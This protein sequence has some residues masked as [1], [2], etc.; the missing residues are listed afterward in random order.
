M[1]EEQWKP[2][3][4]VAAIIERDKRFLIVEE[5]INGQLMLN[6]P[7]GHWEDNETLVEAAIR[8]TLEETAWHFS[9]EALVGIYQWKHP[10]SGDT[11]L[12]FAFTGS[13]TSHEAG[14]KL[15]QGIMRASWYS[16]DEL[17]ARCDQHRS[18]QLMLCIEDYL[19]GQRYPLEI[20]RVV[21]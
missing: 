10:D 20:L 5:E 8:E 15:D 18:P 21:K 14:Q 1:N 6:Q 13:I 7:A 9:P 2:R 11:Y 19:R 12:R 17:K 3:A 4:T 16:V